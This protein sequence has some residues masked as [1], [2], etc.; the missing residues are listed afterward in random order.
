MEC[1]ISTFILFNDSLAEG[2]NNISRLMTVSIDPFSYSNQII[3][4]KCRNEFKGYKIVNTGSFK[5]HKM[6]AWYYR[7]VDVP[8][9]FS[10]QKH[11]SK[12]GLTEVPQ[13][14]LR[15][16]DK[17]NNPTNYYF[18]VNKITNEYIRYSYLDIDN[19]ILSTVEVPLGIGSLVP[20]R[21]MFNM[22]MYTNKKA[23]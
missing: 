19:K 21:F 2:R 4:F 10:W 13:H 16:Y 9:Y 5:I 18:I 14:T 8:S 22:K 7:N 1:C 11:I 3:P 12:Y 6:I 15:M 20:E 23:S 17:Q